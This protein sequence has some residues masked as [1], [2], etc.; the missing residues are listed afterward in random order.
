MDV[1]NKIKQITLFVILFSS[2]VVSARQL[3]P[4]E[5]QAIAKG[6]VKKNVSLSGTSKS[7][8]APGN[9]QGSTTSSAV[10][11]FNA[12][13]GKGFAVIAGDD[14]VPSVL[15]YSDKSSF[16]MSNAPEG[17][18]WM[19]GVY[20]RMIEHMTSTMRDNTPAFNKSAIK[21][22]EAVEPLIKTQWNQGE[23]YNNMCPMI[24]GTKTLTGCVATA[25][26]QLLKLY[27]RS[28]SNKCCGCIHHKYQ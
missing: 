26:A 24:G 23:P 5:A 4:T 8:K 25:M 13:D 19:I 3:S 9:V 17:A 2:V 22:R 20:E 16:D 14:R 21:S 12:D 15:A 27:E 18:K 11:V 6:I 7:L 1:R 28:Y 10:Y